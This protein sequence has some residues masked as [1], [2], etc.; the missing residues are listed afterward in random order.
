MPYAPAGHAGAVE[1]LLPPHRAEVGGREVFE[2][3]AEAAESGAHAGQKDDVCVGTLSLHGGKLRVRRGEYR[4]DGGRAVGRSVLTPIPL[5][6]GR[7]GRARQYP[8]AMPSLRGS[9]PA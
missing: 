7:G 4:A 9:E 5:P 3:T 6:T 2:R 1:R 8:A